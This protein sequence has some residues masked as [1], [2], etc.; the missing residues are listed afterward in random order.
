MLPRVENIPY[1]GIRYASLLSSKKSLQSGPKFPIL[2]A[3]NT[4]S[5]HDRNLFTLQQN[6]GKLQ[7]N[8]LNLEQTIEKMKKDR[9]LYS[10]QNENH[11]NSFT[12]LIF[13][14]VGISFV[15]IIG[16]KFLVSVVSSIFY[17]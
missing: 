12:K 5:T 10:K 3:N 13:G 11:S 2:I 1:K 8:I 17:T 16:T 9:I 6:I 7:N 14:F 4:T 15:A